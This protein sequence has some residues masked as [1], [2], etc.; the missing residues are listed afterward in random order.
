MK[1]AV[2]ATGA[3]KV[4]CA[5]ETYDL[6][7]SDGSIL[8]VVTVWRGVPEHIAVVIDDASPLYAIMTASTVP[9]VLLGPT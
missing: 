3:S 5:R 2:V 4:R 7:A 9:T 8:N 6:P 1:K